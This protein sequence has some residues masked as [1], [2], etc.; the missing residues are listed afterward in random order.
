MSKVSGVS[1]FPHDSSSDFA[2]F[3]TSGSESRLSVCSYFNASTVPIPVR[4][5]VAKSRSARSLLFA[6]LIA[7]LI[8]ASFDVPRRRSIFA[9]SAFKQSKSF[10]SGGS[11]LS[12]VDEAAGAG[13]NVC[14]CCLVPICCDPDVPNPP[15]N[16]PPWLN[17]P[18]STPTG[19]CTAGGTAGAGR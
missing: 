10:G 1:G 9:A 16:P 18:T 17:T 14:C 3:A 8:P 6:H 2:D 11:V 13:S 4:I 12:G 5:P 15:P 7:S 19:T